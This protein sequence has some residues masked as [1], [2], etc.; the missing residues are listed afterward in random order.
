MLELFPKIQEI[1]QN[2]NGEKKI[3]KL[4]QIKKTSNQKLNQY[5]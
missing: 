1:Y 3:A 5:N 4:I 2:C